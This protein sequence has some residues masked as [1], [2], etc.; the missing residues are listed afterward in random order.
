MIEDLR[1]GIETLISLYEKE[2]RKCDELSAKLSVCEAEIEGNKTRIAELNDKLKKLEIARA[3]DGED[4]S[5]EAK[6]NI[7]ALVRRIDQCIAL[8]EG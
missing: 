6:R 7:D 2:C 5:F 1:Q 8:L 3:F 4:T